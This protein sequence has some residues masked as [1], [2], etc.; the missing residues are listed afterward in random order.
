MIT[1]SEMI[2]FPPPEPNAS[3]QKK[4]H[5]PLS[6]V[7]TEFHAILI[8]KNNKVKAVSLLNKELVHDEQYSESLGN[9]IDIVKDPIKH[10]IWA[11]TSKAV[12]RYK[13]SREQRNVWQIYTE[14]KQFELARKFCENNPAHLDTINVKQAELLFDEGQFEKSAEIFAE[15]QS[16]FESICLKFLDNDK[17]DALKIFLRKKL[18]NLKPQ[19]KIQT[20]MLVVWIVE[21]Y[22]SQL[23]HLQHT[24]PLDTIKYNKLQKDFE[25]FLCLPNVIDCIKRNKP[26]I[27]DLMSSHGDKDNLIKLTV[28]NRDF[29][30]LIRQH[31]FKKSY[32]EALGVLKSQNKRELFYQFAPILLQEVPKPTVTALIEQGKNLNP[33]KLLAALVSCD[34]DKPHIKEMIRYLEY[35]IQNLGCTDQAIHNYLLTLYVEHDEAAL[36]RYLASQGQVASLVNYDIHYAL[37]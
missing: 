6:F 23:S 27:Y 25:S 13:V 31:I 20:T 16:S 19:D 12:F 9:L 26:V 1:D 15:T 30:N 10:T 14:K 36:M 34:I 17:I 7:L 37:R 22:L 29:E 32:P 11:I 3:P 18:N 2:A 28:I 8:Y 24:D 33:S 5:V 4:E 21:L 35:C